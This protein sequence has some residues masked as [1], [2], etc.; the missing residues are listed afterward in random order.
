[1]CR[2]LHSLRYWDLVTENSL[3]KA[4]LSTA[5]SLAPSMGS[6]QLDA[7]GILLCSCHN[8]R[9]STHYPKLPLL[10]S[11]TEWT[12][13]RKENEAPGCQKGLR[14]SYN[15]LLGAVPFSPDLTLLN[16]KMEMISSNSQSRCSAS[17]Y[18]G[19]AFIHEKTPNVPPFLSIRYYGLP[20]LSF[21]P[22]S[23]WSSFTP[24]DSRT[25]L[26]FL[27]WPKSPPLR[28]DLVAIVL[29]QHCLCETTNAPPEV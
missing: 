5:G 4:V 17:M 6:T 10:A 1:M 12:E 19:R 23:A 16:C 2:L 22:H 25:P 20:F 15:P 29:S 7:P 9:V 27:L 14:L 26:L 3:R 8:S 11:P 28:F 24:W 21:L 18:Y 13:K